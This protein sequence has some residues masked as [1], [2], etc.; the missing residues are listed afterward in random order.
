MC[1]CVVA[2][3]SVIADRV[4]VCVLCVCVCVCGCMY[5][6]LIVY[7]LCDSDMLCFAHRVF[8]C[9]IARCYV[10]LTVYLSV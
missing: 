5:V 10:L 4:F 8:V 6:L 7:L 1:V 3:Y 9:V 2:R